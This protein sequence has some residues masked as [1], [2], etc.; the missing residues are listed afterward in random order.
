LFLKKRILSLILSVILLHSIAPTAWALSDSPSVYLDGKRLEFEVPPTIIEGSTL[1]PLRKI[2]EEQGAQVS[3]DSETRTV[4]AVKG[5]IK[6]TYT[7]GSKTAQKNNEI[8]SLSVPGQIIDGSTLVP[9]R[10]VSEAMGGAVGWE[11][12]SR[13]ITI[14]SAVKKAIKVDRVVDGDTIEVNWDGKTEKIRLIGMDTPESVHPDMTKNS[15]AGNTASVNTK[16]QLEGK[17][18]Q[19]EL[20]V[21]ERDR[22][23]RLLGYIFLED[24]TFYNAKLVSEGY[25]KIAT[26]PPNVR[27][28]ELYKQLQVNAREGQRGLWYDMNTGQ[29][30]TITNENQTPTVGA[31]GKLVIVSVDKDKEIVA[32]RNEDKKIVD[33][34][35][36]KLVS[37]EGNQFFI[38][39]NNSS[40]E[41]NQ[42]LYIIS[43]ANASTN[44]PAGEK[45]LI[46][47]TKYIWNNDKPD[48][49][50]LYDM[51]GNIISQ[52]E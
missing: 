13:T 17:T 11:N 31:L 46:W 42:T 30:E 36:W 8:L 6:I 23:G 9:L 15:E 44:A 40:I 45:S 24:G 26:F 34:S 47:T 14:S 2:F 41:P 50:E 4:T 39:P 52:K 28:V 5:I 18:V 32:I 22:Y 51:N 19:V 7:I 49:A 48:P 12:Y 37:V 16:E 25:A 27:W 20:D 38:F 33:L 29:S 21:E 10:F 43:G 3:W 35:G 1:V